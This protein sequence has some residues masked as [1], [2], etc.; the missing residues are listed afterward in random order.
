M[1]LA[2]VNKNRRCII[3]NCSQKKRTE[4]GL[5]PAMVRYDGPLFRVIRNFLSNSFESENLDVYILSAKYGVLTHNK[6]IEFYDQLLSNERIEELK[7]QI[8]EVLDKKHRLNQYNE[9]FLAVGN[10]YKGLLESCQSLSLNNANLTV[11]KGGIGEKSKFLKNWL[12]KVSKNENVIKKEVKFR[13]EAILCGAK[14]KMEVSQII[15]IANKFLDSEPAKSQNFRDWYVNIGEMKV[16]P[17]WLASRISRIPVSK[18][19]SGEARR[20]LAQL[21]LKSHRKIDKCS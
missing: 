8:A 11:A 20:T 19:T 17:K 9:V 14:I 21:G 16:S 3:V 13:G 7:P 2:Q 18:F 1:N 4:E 6:G 12:Y 10:K 15:E 5:L